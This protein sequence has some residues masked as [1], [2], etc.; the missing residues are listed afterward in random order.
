MDEPRFL[1]VAAGILRREG[2][3]LACQRRAGDRFGLKWELPGGKLRPGEGAAEAL[4]RELREELGIDSRPGRQVG[5]I[6]HR[7]EGGTNVRLFFFEIERFEGEPANLAFEEIRW[8]DP[9]ELPDL[10]W[11]DADRP[12]VQRLAT[13]PASLPAGQGPGRPGPARGRAGI[14]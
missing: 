6:E 13:G 1:E 7:Y 3:I 11:L 5:R 14:E 12:V 10:D 4:V 2:R 8:T 9:A